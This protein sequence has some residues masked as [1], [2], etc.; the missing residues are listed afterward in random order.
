MNA[1]AYLGGR[2]RNVFGVQSPVDGPPRL[3]GIVAP[4][5]ARRRNGDVDPPRI[6]GIENDGVQ[7][8][9]PCAGLPL[10]PGAV[11]AQAGEFLPVLSAVGSAKNRGI[12]HAGVDR[13]GVRQ[14]W[15]QV[16]NPLEL[17]GVRRAVIPLVR[18]RDAR[19]RKL[20]SHRFPGYAAVLRALDHLPKPAARLRSI[21]AVGIRRR[22]LY[23]VHLP[24]P[25]VGA[26]HFPVFPFAVRCKDEGAFARAYQDSYFTH[27]FPF[28]NS[29]KK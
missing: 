11:F 15:L 27:I 20:V 18:A 1:M 26:A 7:A 3:P 8:H 25:E 5:G 22:A 29:L 2:H 16:P 9:A 12:L 24:T 14:R 10:W 19:I 23:V 21:K 28:E 17:P 13:I 6:A 4:E